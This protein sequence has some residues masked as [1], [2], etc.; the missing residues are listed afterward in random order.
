MT[1]IYGIKNKINGK[2]YIGQSINIPR[3]WGDHKKRSGSNLKENQDNILY[4]AIRK[5]GLENFDFIIIEECN[6]EKLDEREIY[7]IK[8]H[9]STDKNKGYNISLGGSGGVTPVKITEREVEE[10]RRL[11]LTSLLLQETIAQQFGISQQMVSYINQGQSWFSNNYKYPIRKVEK[12]KKYCI[13]CQ[14]E[15]FETSLRCSRC[16]GLQQRKVERPSPLELAYLVVEKGF[17]GTGE[18]FGVSATAIKKWC[19]AYNIPHLKLELTKWYYERSG[20]QPP[21]KTK[22]KSRIKKVKQ[23][24]PVTNEIIEV[25]ENATAAARKFGGV[26]GSHISEVCNGIHKTAYGF[27]WEYIEE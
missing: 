25:H 6:K 15:I 13:D 21:E 7:W 14:K 1:G 22:K 8:K 2:I 20:K 10:I 4:K 5:Y 16:A 18:Y 9:N 12:N 17:S 24:D 19:R 26:K 27:K 11:L 3:R 23:I